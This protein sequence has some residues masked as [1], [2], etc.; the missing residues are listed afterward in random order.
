M[1]DNTTSLKPK[2]SDKLFSEIKLIFEKDSYN[3][4]TGFQSYENLQLKNSDRYQFI[5]PYY[6]FNQ[7]LF[8]NFD[9]GSLTFNSNGS[10]DLKLTNLNRM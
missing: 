10:N 9:K 4:T 2:N 5:L 8:T 3:F 7:N 6:D 1:I